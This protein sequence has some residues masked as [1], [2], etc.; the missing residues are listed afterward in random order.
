MHAMPDQVR[1]D[2]ARKTA[3]AKGTPEENAG[4]ATHVGGP[5]KHASSR[6][7]T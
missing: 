1:E 2:E 4:A 7:D 5:V 6:G 3:G